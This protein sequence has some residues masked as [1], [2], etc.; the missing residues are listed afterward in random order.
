MAA[1]EEPPGFAEAWKRYYT[2]SDDKF[3]GRRETY[4]LF[5]RAGIDAASKKEPEKVST[6]SRQSY[7]ARAAANEAAGLKRGYQPPNPDLLDR[8][9]RLL[10]ANPVGMPNL[11]IREA[12]GGTSKKG[13]I[14]CLEHMRIHGEAFPLRR[15]RA[16]RWA[17]EKHRKAAVN[18]PW[19]VAELAVN[20]A[21]LASGTV[22]PLETRQTV[23]SAANADRIRTA[24]VS[25]VFALG[26]SQ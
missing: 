15:G 17:L 10:D 14:L 1:V 12:V 8:V 24:A 9:R 26:G 21:K 25:S 22:G 20:H 11:A 3:P 23:V 4:A 2:D 5:F 19:S 18:A 7:L 16:A 13:I 6:Y